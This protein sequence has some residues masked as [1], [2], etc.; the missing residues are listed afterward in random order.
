[1]AE[2]EP[3]SDTEQDVTKAWAATQD[4]KGKAKKLR[5]FAALSWV[6]A[7]GTE[8]AGIVLILKNKFDQGNLALLIGLFVVIGIFAIAGSI[9]WKKANRHDPASKEEP[10][11]FFIQNQLGAIITLIAFLPLLAMIFLDKDMDPKT[12]K[13]A[14]G[15]GAVLA[16]VATFVFGADYNPPS[17]EQYTQDMN[18]CAEQIKAKQPTTACS[19]AV[20]EQAQDIARDSEAVAEATGGQDVVY[21]IAP[22]NGAE[23]SSS[24]LVFHLCE[25]VSTLRGKVVNSGSVTEAYAQNAVRLTKQIKMEQRQCGFEVAED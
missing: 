22:K 20:A 19:P 6:V 1:M 21:W 4:Q 8:I 24:K 5:T 13:I 11:K 7:I 3:T 16:L 23:K 10:V 15:F 2:Q 14:G 9:M 18:E 12:K 25:D 17:V